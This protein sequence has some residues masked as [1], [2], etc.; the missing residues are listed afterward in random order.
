VTSYVFYFTLQLGQ[1]RHHGGVLA[2]VI[3]VVL[4]ENRPS[5]LPEDTNVFFDMQGVIILSQA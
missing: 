5:L 4:W 3:Q 1:L 2:Q